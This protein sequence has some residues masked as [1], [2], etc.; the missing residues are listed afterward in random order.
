[1]GDIFFIIDLV[2]VVGKVEIVFVVILSK[3]FCV[4]IWEYLGEF[5]DG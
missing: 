3:V 5:W 4:V 1:M 2:E